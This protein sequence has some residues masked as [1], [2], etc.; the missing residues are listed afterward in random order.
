MK[1]FE[2]I[3]Q[4]KWGTSY[5]SMRIKHP[6]SQSYGTW[7]HLGRNITHECLLKQSV[8]YQVLNAVQ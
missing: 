4:S 8:F 2:R 7:M 5:K 6:Q 3:K 1:V